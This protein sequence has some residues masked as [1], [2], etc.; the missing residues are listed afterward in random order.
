MPED[1][2]PLVARGKALV[3]WCQA[4]LAGLGISGFHLE[5]LPTIAEAT[6]DLAEIEKLDYESLDGETEEDARAFEEI[7]EYVRTAAMLICTEILVKKSESNTPP[8]DKNVH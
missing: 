6:K 3:T 4:F 8:N 2:Q 7:F 1:D 5:S